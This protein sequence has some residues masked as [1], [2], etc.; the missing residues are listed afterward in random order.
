MQLAYRRYAAPI[1]CARSVLGAVRSCL[2]RSVCLLVF[3]GLCTG[4][5]IAQATATP[6]SGAASAT[7]WLPAEAAASPFVTNSPT[8]QLLAGGNF[9][10]EP[11][12]DA[13]EEGDFEEEPLPDTA[14]GGDF[15]DFPFED[16]LPG[17]DEEEFIPGQIPAVIDRPLGIDEGEIIEVSRFAVAGVQDRPAYGITV[18]AVEALIEEVRLSRPTGFT[19]GRLQEASEVITRYYRERGLI[20][21]QAI[22]PVQQVQ[23]GIVRMEVLEG[24]LGRVLVEGNAIYG[25]PTLRAPF[26]HLVDQ[27]VDAQSIETGLLILTDLPG[28]TV[29][30]LFQPGQLV[31][32]ADLVLKVQDEQRLAGTLRVDQHG[33]EQTGRLRTRAVL[34]LNN[35]TS[36]GD[37][38]ELLAQQTFDPKQQQLFRGEYRRPMGRGYYFGGTMERNS[39]SVAQ[40]GGDISSAT[41]IRSLYLGRQFMRSRKWNLAFE[42]GFASKETSSRIVAPI[43]EDR[44]SVASFR[45]DYDLVDT[46][47][48]GL[49][50]AYVQYFHGIPN[51]L[52]SMGTGEQIS[53]GG[54][55][56]SSR[57]GADGA[58]G[59][60]DFRKV[61]FG[62]T[63]LQTLTKNH[64]LLLRSEF[65]WSA[66][67]LVPLEQLSI[68]GPDN[69]RGY[70]VAERLWDTGVFFSLEYLIN[71]PLV[72]DRIA[73]GNR[74]WGEL[75][76]LSL[77]VDQATGKLNDPIASEQSGYATYR[78]AG[79]GFRFNLPGA[80]SS[81][82][83]AAWSV[84]G[85]TPG[86]DRSPQVWLEF[87]YQL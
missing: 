58:L 64:S 38:V 86:N 13:M 85:Q 60:G 75:L 37:R 80:F 74:T 61:G 31:G 35:P 21:A 78:A 41:S 26:Q 28:L 36:G 32:T 67:L 63:R 83:M 1:R 68:G 39:F 6:G 59:G 8:M 24:R 47:F 50:F 25:K 40:P 81:R 33:T 56:R 17:D 49:N 12:P 14:E 70:P 22:I 46:R 84:G 27:P 3:S 18:A 69:V 54:G 15:E 23:D 30:G 44:L 16:E 20:L 55:T 77:F 57:Q 52:S 51:F 66:D 42:L 11:L 73:F 4:F 53:A 10:E 79:A 65:Q 29:F 71:A 76:Q 9:E 62:L 48:Q 34:S 5:P 7:G 19:I 87:S 2:H 82:A 43:S 45:L 72:T